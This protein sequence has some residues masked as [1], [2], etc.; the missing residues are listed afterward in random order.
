M[1]V[2]CGWGGNGWGRAPRGARGL[3]YPFPSTSASQNLSRPA[4]GA[5]IEIR[6]FAGHGLPTGSRAP[7]GAR[8][9]KSGPGGAA[10]LRV[11]SRPAR[12]AWIEI[13]PLTAIALQRR[14]AP[15][16]GRVGEEAID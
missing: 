5:W 2:F 13:M 12:G 15:R 8:G 7:R 3:K 16:E 6:I 4:R 9:L 1:F 14:V 11:L 10:D